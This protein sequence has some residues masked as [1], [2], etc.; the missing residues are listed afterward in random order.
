VNA[1]YEEYL[2]SERWRHLR[3][4]KLR[5]GEWDGYGN[6]KCPRCGLYVWQSKMHVHHTTYARIF[7]EQLSDLILLCE[8]C[9]SVEH[10]LPAPAWWTQ[11][12]ADGASRVPR[13]LYGVHSI[14]ESL[15][16]LIEKQCLLR[17]YQSAG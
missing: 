6:C 1:T 13:E 10:G 17:K 8:G 12:I 9:H 15:V 14:G 5:T 16:D 4:A 7:R 2:K 11:C 3:L